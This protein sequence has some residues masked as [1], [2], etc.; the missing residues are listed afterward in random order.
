M[1]GVA[2]ALVL[3]AASPAQADVGAYLGRPV[4]AVGFMVEGE[5]LTDARVMAATLTRVGEPLSLGAVRESIVHLLNLGLFDDVVVEAEAAGSAVALTYRLTPLHP[6][7][8]VAFAGVDVPGVGAGALRRLVRERFGESPAA[9]RVDEIARVVE[10]QLRGR[11][12]L[13]ARAQPRVDVR[14]APHESILTLVIE[15]GQRTRVGDITVL[16]SPG[17]SRDALLDRLGLRA[18]AP[19]QPD[20]L[21]ARIARHLDGEREAGRFL[22]RLTFAARFEDEDAVAHVTVTADAG[23]RVRIEFTGDPLPADTRATLVPIATEASV[24]EDVLED[25][26]L[27]IEDYLQDQGYRDATAAYTRQQA[28]EELVITFTIVRGTQYRLSSDIE[29]AGNVQVPSADLAPHV[30]LRAGQPFVGAALDATVAAIED[31]YHRRGFVA[32]SVQSGVNPVPTAAQAGMLLVRIVITENVRT[33]VGTVRLEGHTVPEGQLLETLG[34]RAGDPF[35]VATL[36]ADRDRLQLG[37]ANL[38]YHRATVTAIPVLSADGTRADVTFRVNEGPATAVQHVLIVGNERT[39]ASTIA[40]EVTVAPGDPLG[41]DTLVDI[42]NRLATLGLFRRVRV[43]LLDHGEDARRDLLVNVEEAPATTVGYGGGI[44]VAPRIRSDEQGAAVQQIEF[45]PRAFVELGRRNLFGKN[46]SV[47]LFGS[48][49]FLP[50]SEVTGEAGS[51]DGTTPFGFVE[52]RA[53]GTFREPRVFDTTADAAV[54]VVAEQQA[55][56]SFNFWRQAVTA[57]VG[58]PLTRTISVSGN[59]QLERTRTFDEQF[60]YE[61]QLLID[62]LFPQVRLSSFSGS[63]VRDTRDDQVNPIRGRY[64]S[65]NVQLAARAIGSEVGFF[66][67]YLTG[68]IFQ[69]LG[70]RRIVLAASARV[71][72]ATGFPRE[73]VQTDEDGNPILGPD[74]QPAVEVIEDLPASERFFAG[75]DTTVRG[76]ALDQLGTP[77]TIDQNGFPLGG[78]A[79]V[80]FN[81]E[82]RVPLFA[83]LGVVGFVDAGNVFARTSDM[84]FGEIRGALGFGVRYASP[85]GPIRVDLGFKTDRRDITPGNRES[86]T[87]LHISLGQAF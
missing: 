5:A 9:G 71:G 16:G 45:A 18:R 35:V 73:L 15:P 23:P 81:A 54:S 27:R 51:G 80:I 26:R 78:H 1:R 48:I 14:H 68:Q 84:D 62:R 32:V 44:E 31:L 74:G 86:L 12:Y 58:R 20:D 22:A 43:G 33:R 57:T 21:A 7:A 67:S 60:T 59:Y 13:R 53:L 34:L 25:A 76:F 69:P 38:G 49:G 61:D 87:A 75:G 17:I 85:V 40:R 63:I 36:A 83:G 4:S 6:I 11:G 30:Q 39:R 29:I 72:M 3:L 19:Y 41:L 28:G 24:S 46:R 82:L 77:E 52:Y 64:A 70:A 37:Y 65:G 55:R 47:S 50:E 79:V 10:E 2:L 66:R 42:Q 56:S 8:D